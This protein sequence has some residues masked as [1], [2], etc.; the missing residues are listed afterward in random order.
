MNTDFLKKHSSC[1]YFFCLDGGGSKTALQVLDNK[2]AVLLLEEG[3]VRATTLI[4]SGSNIN[5]FGYE[6]VALTLKSLFKNLSIGEE[7]YSFEAIC[8]QSFLVAGLAGIEASKENL[9]KIKALFHTFGFKK[10][11]IFI[12]SDVTVA[13]NLLGEDGALLIAGTGSIC[14][15]KIKG[16]ER[17]A[18]GYGPL[19]GDEGSGFD[20]GKKTL[21]VALDDDSLG[22]HSFSLTSRLCDYFKVPSLASIVSLV[23]EGAIKPAQIAGITPYV[24]EEAYERNDKPCQRILFEAASHLAALVN[25][26]SKEGAAAS[27]SLPLY[28]IGGVFKNQYASRFIDQLI[29]EIHFRNFSS[30][31]LSAENIPAFLV[32]EFLIDAKRAV[33]TQSL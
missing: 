14:F 20:I 1:R 33:R 13:K 10:E 21:Q 31:N 11:H 29:K 26:V 27:S 19:L 24:F 8:H 25:S 7:G 4:T 30:V 5:T 12:G 15:S 17:R 23:Y 16:M 32:R 28:L 18:G 6:E 22:L 3:V 2:G 9:E